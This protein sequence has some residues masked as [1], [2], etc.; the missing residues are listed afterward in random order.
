[1]RPLKKKKKLLPKFCDRPSF[2][3]ALTALSGEKRCWS[4]SRINRTL[5]RA[6]WSYRGIVPCSQS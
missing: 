1:M 6:R 4:T 5:T 3:L 2:M